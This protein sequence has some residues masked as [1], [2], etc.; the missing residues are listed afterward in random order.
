LLD[1]FEP[2]CG[3]TNHGDLS[4]L[5]DADLADLVAYLDTL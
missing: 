4:G 3:G 2:S 5:T 1:R